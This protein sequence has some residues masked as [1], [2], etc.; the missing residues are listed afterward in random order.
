MNNK[1]ENH[2]NGKPISWWALS[3]L[4]GLTLISGIIYGVIY[5]TVPQFNELFE[6]F[7]SE[8]PLLTI[9]V[10]NTYM[11]YGLFFLIGF[12]PCIKLFRNRNAATGNE[13]KLS[14]IVV[15]NFILAILIQGFVLIGLYYPVFQMGE[16]T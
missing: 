6:S 12:V 5:R 1:T 13:I 14:L 15:S 11:F 9:L 7:G 4:I 16:V 10:L 8:L 3:L 2:P